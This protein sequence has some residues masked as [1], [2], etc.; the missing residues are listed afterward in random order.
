MSTE[1]TGDQLRFLDTH[2]TYSTIS[3]DSQGNAN[4]GPWGND[5]YPTLVLD[6]SWSNNGEEVL[7]AVPLTGTNHAIG[8]ATVALCGFVTKSELSAITTVIKAA[9]EHGGT[10]NGELSALQAISEE[11]DSDE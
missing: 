7:V 4:D 8:I 5:D 1:S 10:K 11:E 3:T 6:G 2:A 9:V